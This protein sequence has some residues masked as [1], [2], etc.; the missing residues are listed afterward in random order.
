MV[1][2]EYAE[3]RVRARVTQALTARAKVSRPVAEAALA[4]CEWDADAAFLQLSSGNNASNGS[5]AEEN[6]DDGAVLVKTPSLRTARAHRNALLDRLTAGGESSSAEIRNE[7]QLADTEIMPP[8]VTTASAPMS[9]S[10]DDGANMVRTPSAGTARRQR[11]AALERRFGATAEMTLPPG[12][13]QVDAAE[14]MSPPNKQRAT[15]A[16]GSSSDTIPSSPVAALIRTQSAE[17][18]L[19]R[20]TAEADMAAEQQRAAALEAQLAAVNSQFSPLL[21]SINC[22]EGAGGDAGDAQPGKFQLS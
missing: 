20:E 15:E 17:E 7:V 1:A 18:R 6:E 13:V 8:P 12:R 19:L 22:G 16:L 9:V 2:Q 11:L 5:V 21:R 4:A 3:R 14:P 10:T